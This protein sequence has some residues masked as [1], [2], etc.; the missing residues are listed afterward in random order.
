VGSAKDD[1]ADRGRLV[2]HIADPCTQAVVVERCRAEEP[3]LFLRCEQELDAPVLP[4]LRQHA[5][6]PF[7]HHRD[8]RFVVRAQDRAAGVPHDA[9]VDHRLDR[10]LGRHR[11]EVRAEEDRRPAVG[12]LQPAIDVAHVR[13][14]LCARVVLVDREPEVAQ[15]ADDDVGDL[16]LLA[17]RARQCGELGEEVDDLGG[18]AADLRES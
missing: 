12:R 16:A 3:N 14:H 9:V 11:V 7:E 1:V 10:A 15:V 6:Y 17:G 5:P 18:H 8:G 4:V 13:A 2:V